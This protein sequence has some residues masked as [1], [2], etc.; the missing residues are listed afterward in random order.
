M[1]LLPLSVFIV[2]GMLSNNIFAAQVCNSDSSLSAK[3]SNFTIHD[4]GTV[5]DIRTSLTWMRCAL[6][7]EW[8]DISQT[9]LGYSDTFTWGGALTISVGLNFAEHNDWRVP[10]IKELSSIID[11]AC[12]APSFNTEVFPNLDYYSS[13]LSSTPGHLD[14]EIWVASM[15]IP[16]IISTKYPSGAVLLVR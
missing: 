9:C 1:K 5:T 11:F 2:T 15:N 14:S 13:Y 6:G 4:N 16:S 8:D 7:Q 3:Y 10:N 12:T